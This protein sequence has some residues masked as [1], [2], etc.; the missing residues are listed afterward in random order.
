MARFF[1][2]D[3]IRGIANRPPI[4]PETFMALGHIVVQLLG[5]STPEA[6]P[7]FVVGY[8]TRLSSPML[9]AAL[10]A[11]LCSAGAN[12]LQ[13]GIMPTPGVAYLTRYTRATGGLVISASHNS[14]EDNGLKIFSGLGT[15]LHDE[16]EELIE[17]RLDQPGLSQG[18]TGEAVGRPIPYEEG[19]RHYSTFLKDL[20][21]ANT[22]SGLRVGLDCAHGA[23]SFLAPA[24]FEH[25]GCQVY[26]WQIAPDGRN[27]NHQCGAVH[28]SFIQ[29]KVLEHRLDIGFA[30]DGDAD[31]LVAVDHTGTIL[32][33]DDI[34]AICAR[35]FLQ[36][37]PTDRCT[38][39]STVM[40]NLGLEHALRHMGITLH[41][42]PVGDRHVVQGMQQT[43]AVLGGEQSGHIVFGD[44]HTTGDGMLTAIQLLHIVVSQK[45]PL[46]ALAM[47]M[48][49]YPQ[50]IVN[51]PVRVRQD[52]LSF[53]AIRQVI[54]EAG[55]TLGDDGRVVVRLS[56]TENVVRIMVEAPELPI[57]DCLSQNI[58]QAITQVLGA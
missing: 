57:V 10:T 8:D 24:L 49:K 27:I 48:H 9:A 4:A 21:R 56:G 35:A 31:R 7:V 47:S 16:L 42:T 29:R 52:P 22:H 58:T 53:P 34:L 12:V 55:H 44:H 18:P 33:G 11:G 50:R 37:T 5:A 43:G 51:V 25:L 30:F 54:E 23:A 40:A 3:G 46:A 6:Q 17:A 28:P 39:V 19:S 15:K 14:Y 2:T 36:P 1:G 26:A 45:L 20:Y 38:V 13:V 41:R 32:D